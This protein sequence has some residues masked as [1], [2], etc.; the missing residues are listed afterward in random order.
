MVQFV[1]LPAAIILLMLLG[2]LALRPG[3]QLPPESLPLHTGDVSDA[4]NDLALRTPVRRRARLHAPRGTVRLIAAM[5]RCPLSW[6]A[7]EAL[8]QHSRAMMALLMTLHR[9]LRKAPPLP[10][11]DSG[12]PRMLLLGRELVRHGSSCDAHALNE[13]LVTWDEASATTHQER[14]LL[15]LC[16]RLALAEALHAALLSMRF[17]LR[18]ARRGDQLARRLR[19]TRRPVALLTRAPMTPACAHALLVRLRQQGQEDLLTTTQDTLTRRGLAPDE[20]ASRHGKRQA[21]CAE[22]LLRCLH[23]LR[24]LSSL[25]WAQVEEEADPLHLLLLDDPSGTYPRMTAGSR[26]C[27]REQAARLARLFHVEEARLMRDAL[28]LCRT[29]EPDTPMHH[30]GWYLLAADGRMALRRWLK[31]RP[32]GLRLWL[33]QR[34]LTVYRTVLIAL[35]ALAAFAFLQTGFSLWM[36]P[37]FLL[38]IGPGIRWAVDALLRRMPAP[39]VPQMQLD[40]VPEELRTLVVMP[41]VLHGRNEA[42]P[43]VRRLL[44]ARHAMPP[45]AVDCLLLADHGDSMT[46]TS[47]EDSVLMFAATRA[48]EAIDRPDSRFFYLHRSRS[49]DRRLHRYTGRGG[50]QGLMA[51]LRQLISEGTCPDGFDAA[52]IPP[53]VFHNRYTHVLMLPMDCTPAPDMLLP[54]LGAMTHP[55]NRHAVLVRP[56]VL[57]DPDSLRTRMGQ[58]DRHHRPDDPLLGLT[59][60]G[61][62]CSCC[63]FDPGALA[64][65]DTACPPEQLTDAVMGALT[66]CLQ[67][68]DSTIYRHRPAGMTGWM[69]QLH[70]CTQQSWRQLSW[71]MPWRTVHGQ[72]QRNPMP[73]AGRFRLRR[74]LMDTLTAPAQLTMLVYAV[75]C[76]NL[77]LMLAS[78]LLPELRHA[79]PLT[80]HIL[81]HLL[82]RWGML[83]LRAFM[84]VDGMGRGLLTLMLSHEPNW[85]SPG[86][87]G[88]SYAA[89][90][91]WSQTLCAAGMVGA[92]FLSQPPCWFGLL[93]GAAFACF[94]LMHAWLDRPLRRTQPLNRRMTSALQELAQATWH[95]FEETVTADAPLPPGS[96]QLK[97]YRGANTTVT[98]EDIGLYLLSC[99]AARHL[100]LISATEMAQRIAR[101]L[102]RL[103]ALPRW[104]GLPF[105][106]Y[107]LRTLAP[108]SPAR[109]DTEDCGVLCACLLC[110][111]QGLRAALP[112]TDS[113]YIGLAA[114]VDA[115]AASLP[116]HQLYDPVAGLF[117]RGID[118]ET[119]VPEKEHCRLYASPGLLTSFVAVMRHEVPYAHLDNLSRVQVR[120]HQDTPLCSSHGAASSY[121]MPLLLLP[122]TP[123]TP[124]A[125]TVD[126][127]IRAQKRHSISGMFGTSDCAQWCFDGQMNYLHRPLGLPELALTAM[128][129]CRVIAPY[130]AALCLP[131]DP[132]AACDSLMH[133]RSH[134]ASGP[135]GFYD[136][137][138]MEMAHLPEGV[139]EEVTQCHVTAHQAMV[140]C[141]LCNAL[142]GDSLTR[143][144]MAIP[145]AAASALLLR[146]PRA[147]AV[148]LPARHVR[149]A[150][151]PPLEPSFRREARLT[152]LP[153]DAHVIGTPEASLLLSAQ[154][155][156]VMRTRG[157]TLTR[158]TGDPTQVEG[159]QCYI[160]DASGMERLGGAGQEG[161]TV[162]AEG[163]IRLTR[164]IHGLQCTLTALVDPASGT[165]LHTLDIVNLTG[166]E[167]MVEVADCLIPGFAEDGDY[168]IQAAQPTDRA[169]TLTRRAA[170]GEPALTLCHVLTTADPLTTLTAF[171]E[172]GALLGHGG[173]LHAPEP[174]QNG[175]STVTE[176][177]SAPCAGFRM[178]LSLGARGRTQLILTTRLLRPGEAFSLENLT[179]RTT[180]LPGLATLS[181]LACRAVYASLGA[182]QARA[183]LLSCAAGV[184]LWEDQPHQGA[185]T[186]LTRPRNALSDIGLDPALPL[187]TLLLYT[188]SGLPLVRDAADA[189]AWLTL[190]G[191]PAALCVLCCGAEGTAALHA[192]ETALA[193]VPCREHL[194]LVLASDL[195]DGL[196]ETLEA[197]SRLLLYEG[198]GS[199]TQQLEDGWIPLPASAE[200]PVCTDAPRLP[201]EQLRFSHGLGGFQA[202]TDDPILML[203][204][205]LHPPVLWHSMTPSEGLL[206]SDTSAGPGE[207]RLGDVPLLRTDADRPSE[208]IYLTE[209]ERCFS[210]TP[211]PLGRGLAC[212]VQFMPGQTVWNTM[213]YG[214]DMTLTAAIVPGERCG[215]RTLRLKNLTS[216]P[217][218]LRMTLALRMDALSCL[219]EVPGGIAA[220][221]S[222]LNAT[223]WVMSAEAGCT[224]RRM[225]PALFLGVQGGVP[226]GLSLPGEDVGSMALL[227]MPLSLPADGQQA[228]SWMVGV[229]PA[230][231]DMERLL[232]RVRTGG[233]SVIGHQARQ[234][235][236]QRLSVLTVST[237]D[238]SLNL[239]MNRLLPCQWHLPRTDGQRAFAAELFRAA[240]LMLPSPEEARDVLLTC[241]AHQYADGSV[242]HTWRSPVA[243]LRTRLTGECLLLPLMTARYIAVTGN[244][245]LLETPLPWLESPPLPEGTDTREEAASLSAAADT[246]HSHCM[247]ALTSV[248]LGRHGL[249]MMDA[250]ELDFTFS[251]LRGE[252]LYLGCIFA[253][254]LRDYAMVAPPEDRADILEVHRHLTA[255]IERSGWDGAWYLRAWNTQGQPLGSRETAVCQLDSLSQSWAALALGRTERTAQALDAAW[256]TLYD[257]QHGLLR[258]MAPPIGEQ[259][260]VGEASALCPGV[261]RNGGQD[262]LATVW[263]LAA[264]CILHQRDRAWELLHA[265]NPV[266]HTT[267]SDG[268]EGFA[269]A[270]WLLPGGMTAQGRAMAA[271]DGGA[272]GLLYSVILMRMLGLTKQ[273]EHIRLQPMVPKTW[274]MFSL[275][276]RWGSSTWHMEAREDAAAVTCDGETCPDG[277]VVLTDDGRIH[278]VC[279]PIR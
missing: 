169:I 54:L 194:H 182:D 147:S 225:S 178:R 205:E 117:V 77:P 220:S 50:R 265:L 258:C 13:A 34:S 86:Q 161:E 111:A 119:G 197:A 208:L 120:V 151:V 237:P 80:G 26:L 139:R 51:D 217:R 168:R 81:P 166:A 210:P 122:L 18:E 146:Q 221:R 98:P 144:F 27:Y 199:F 249:P 215:L 196:R 5:E 78:L 235:W 277:W 189:V 165:F 198:A 123:G 22:E 238:D 103:D 102:D 158:F 279:V 33:A 227:D 23:A 241:A 256:N 63:L 72:L 43:A 204:P 192:A 49:Y 89:L 91:G 132:S 203:P 184:M 153:V 273:G 137:L 231:D 244:A 248:R 29:A 6:S 106:R 93:L 252:S 20:L 201:E 60:R 190:S 212:R 209:G 157:V 167:R 11:D 140:L 104:Q 67:V 99:L 200:A 126:A 10:A 136:S 245:A 88:E 266:H 202:Q 131:F 176:C 100:Q 232:N 12:V 105:H 107:D 110:V 41:A 25:N 160:G 79:T 152:T 259:L 115:L 260:T 275:T 52:T 85:P 128:P 134:G 113:E 108:L 185:V 257:G 172:R 159:L 101:T 191:Q 1:I 66:C 65:L 228:V 8:R 250:G 112:D 109:V 3:R 21:V 154:G 40:S 16:T 71:L 213:G 264:L 272:A 271:S 239:L 255:A 19:H 181:R 37:F 171:T 145:A 177:P 57:V 155:M 4:V 263:M 15:P 114:R 31:A 150:P 174:P 162:F 218:T 32:G 211:L 180:D 82:T 251:D 17:E 64:R 246:L 148:T 28:T 45:G 156:G 135:M 170:P 163:S 42:I 53:E 247:R 261:G 62:G 124:M 278:Q 216:R 226:A 36:L 46:A 254:A 240:A 230:A 243:G 24:R 207:L 74:T 149:S 267:S 138:D 193:H 262:T 116:L 253:S 48:M 7:V 164:Q 276:L 206:V 14:M 214:L 141:A 96:V 183:A 84:A 35:N 38:T 229:F 92:V 125:R 95:Y 274:D 195:P 68:Q 73:S 133:L 94:P 242:Q 187:M 142:T 76:C 269:L 234:A 97:P 129:E 222:D 127:V 83:P 56:S 69:Q 87:T 173:I 223:L 30:V 143:T 75:L 224:V 44:L 59:S 70:Q 9:E 121:L 268:M 55:L 39:A 270:P 2:W 179:P 186:P 219:T 58:L 118:G 236:A 47:A 188:A 175:L 233:A 130:A 90:E 61:E